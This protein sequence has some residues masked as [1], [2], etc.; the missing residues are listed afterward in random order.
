[1]IIYYKIYQAPTESVKILSGSIG[2]QLTRWKCFFL[3]CVN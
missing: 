3:L 2:L 1:M